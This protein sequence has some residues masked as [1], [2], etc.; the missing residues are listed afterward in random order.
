VR[1]EVY[2][3]RTVKLGKGRTTPEFVGLDVQEN[4][5]EKGFLTSKKTF[6]LYAHDDDRGKIR[7]QSGDNAG[8]S[9]FS[10]AWRVEPP[11]QWVS[12]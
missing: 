7:E 5:E 3:W 10:Q 2:Q 9:N 12:P 11:N 1:L 6:W 8:G 4:R